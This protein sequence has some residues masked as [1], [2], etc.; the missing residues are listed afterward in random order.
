MKIFIAEDEKSLAVSLQ[1]RIEAEN[2]EVFL[3][4]DGESALKEILKNNFDLILLDWK[5]PK[6]SGL[7]VCKK[8]R[9]SKIETPIIFL[10]ALNDISNKVE[11]LKLGADDYLTKPFDFEELLARIN[12][13][14]RRVKN[15]NKRLICGSFCIDLVDH[16][17][18][19]D[20][21]KIK[22]T[23][24]EFE[25]LHFFILHKGEIL[26]KDILIEK[27]WGL[28]FVPETNFIE[29]TIKNLRKKLE[30]LTSSK[31]I[32]TVYGEGYVFIGD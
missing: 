13:I 20:N 18:F 25:L 32:K 22:L 23:E 19:K 10:T 27:V 7:E 29:V 5:M 1:K 17:V 8:I 21:N 3:A 15:Y 28:N 12:S 30:E 26:N 4:F 2:F 31:L 24:K 16:F 14:L 9:E 6:Y 11:A